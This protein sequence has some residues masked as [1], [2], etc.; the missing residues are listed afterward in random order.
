[1]RLNPNPGAKHLGEAWISNQNIFLGPM[2]RSNT[3]WIHDDTRP[4][5]FV[6]VCGSDGSTGRVLDK[7][8]PRPTNNWRDM[9]KL[10][11]CRDYPGS[12]GNP[13]S[14]HPSQLGQV[15]CP[16]S[17]GPGPRSIWLLYTYFFIVRHVSAFMQFIMM[18]AARLLLAWCSYNLYS[19]EHWC[20]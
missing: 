3:E 11:W 1:M 10:D 2:S 6:W 17:C 5:T 19:V 20:G 13:C 12:R 7:V 18:V 9:S 4:H 8:F 16:C 15:L 14:F